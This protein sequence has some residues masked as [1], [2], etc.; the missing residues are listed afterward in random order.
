MCS[1]API[2]NWPTITAGHNKGEHKVRPYIMRIVVY[3]SFS[4][5]T[6]GILRVVLR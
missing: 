6:T 3:P 4:N 1:K 5:T 2:S